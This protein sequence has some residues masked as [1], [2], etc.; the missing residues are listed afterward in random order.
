ME[1]NQQCDVIEDEIPD[2]ERKVETLEENVVNDPEIIV[3][4]EEDELSENDQEKEYELR[5]SS[6]INKDVCLMI[7]CHLLKENHMKQKKEL[8]IPW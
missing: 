3:N 4:D 2:N 8:N 6:R 1:E 5:R 7:M